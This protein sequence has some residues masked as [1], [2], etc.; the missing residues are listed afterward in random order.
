MKKKNREELV[1]QI[2]NLLFFKAL[3]ENISE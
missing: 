2:G 3:R 1:G